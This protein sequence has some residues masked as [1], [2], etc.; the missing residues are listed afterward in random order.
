M[1]DLR[2][3]EMLSKFFHVSYVIVRI[4]FQFFSKAVLKCFD[5]LYQYTFITLI[6]KFFL[7]QAFCTHL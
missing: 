5:T 6:N 2:L 4:N 1:R 3:S 7:I